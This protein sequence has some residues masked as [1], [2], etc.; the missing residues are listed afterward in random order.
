MNHLILLTLVAVPTLA[1]SLLALLLVAGQ[2]KATVTNAAES[3]SCSVPVQSGIGFSETQSISQSPASQGEVIAAATSTQETIDE[4]SS[5]DNLF[6][7]FTT[8][9]SDAAVALFGCDCPACIRALRQMQSQSLSQVLLSSNQ[10][11]CWNALQRRVSPQEA[12]NVLQRLED[13]EAIQN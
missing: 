5:N 6:T 4:S 9:E 12:Q 3:A 1:G 11:H 13:E 2:A 10:G 7:D 8:A